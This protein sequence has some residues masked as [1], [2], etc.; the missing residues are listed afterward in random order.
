[1]IK[2]SS[3]LL[4]QY[5]EMRNISADVFLPNQVIKQN[6]FINNTKQAQKCYTVTII[7]SKNGIGIIRML[8]KLKLNCSKTMAAI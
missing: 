4:N 7:S 3:A 5:Y 1:M 6:L 8:R 2:N